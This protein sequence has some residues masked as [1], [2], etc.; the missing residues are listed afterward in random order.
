MDKSLEYTDIF[1]K[2]HDHTDVLRKY[3]KDGI[4]HILMEERGVSEKSFKQLD[5][6]MSEVSNKIDDDIV[7]EADAF[8]KTGKRLNLYYEIIYDKL[9]NR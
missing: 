8:Y 5:E 2:K 6:L 9:Y 4:T 7:N 3:V 1:G